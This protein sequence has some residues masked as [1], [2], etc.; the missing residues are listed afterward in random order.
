M[1]TLSERIVVKLENASAVLN[2]IQMHV[3]ESKNASFR[4][5]SIKPYFVLC[6]LVFLL[7][8]SV[9]GKTKN[10]NPGNEIGMTKQQI[11]VTGQPMNFN[12]SNEIGMTKQQITDTCCNVAWCRVSNDYCGEPVDIYTGL[13]F[14]VVMFIYDKTG[15]CYKII[16]KNAIEN[17]ITFN[18]SIAYTT[19][20]DIDRGM[21]T[22][23]CVANNGISNPKTHN[24]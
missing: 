3:N 23:T 18:K 16:I 20:T 9:T 15:K 4:F 22:Y 6:V 10:F 19:V 24:K 8:V 7:T 17:P 1:K 11:S 21:I 2:K 12:L 5:R 13:N 14:V